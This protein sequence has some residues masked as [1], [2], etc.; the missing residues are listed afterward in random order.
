VAE[1]M[2]G[3]DAKRHPRAEAGSENIKL[4]NES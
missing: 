2:H 3:V 1:S 4:E